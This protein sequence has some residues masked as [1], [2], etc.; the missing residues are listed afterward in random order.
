MNN[1]Y[2]RFLKLI[3]TNMQKAYGKIPTSQGNPIPIKLEGDL[4]MLNIELS[5]KK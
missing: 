4:L 5:E 3:N 2:M 1:F